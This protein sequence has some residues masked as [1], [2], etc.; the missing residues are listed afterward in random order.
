MVE[1]P[2]LIKRPVIEIEGGLIVGFKATLSRRER[3]ASE[4]EPGEGTNGSSLCS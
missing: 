1:N 3:V 2:T 4:C